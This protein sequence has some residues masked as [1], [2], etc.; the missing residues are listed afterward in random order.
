MPLNNNALIDV[1]EFKEYT[2]IDADELVS[3]KQIELFINYASKYIEDYTA[4]KFRLPSTAYDERFTGDK[5]GKHYTKYWPLVSTISSIYYL[6]DNNWTNALTGVEFTQD[7]D[8]GE[9]YFTD[10]NIFDDAI[11]NYYMISYTYGWAIDDIPDDLKMACASITALRRGQ[12][13]NRLHGISSRTIGTDAKA[14]R[15]NAI[16]SWVLEILEQYKRR[17]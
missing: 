6:S 17:H 5:T 9:I 3:D 16:D 11:E 14:Y 7:N 1:E 4:R 8:N 2:N 15:E 12:F 10:G 13:V